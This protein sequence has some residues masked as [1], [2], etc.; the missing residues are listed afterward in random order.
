MLLFGGDTGKPTAAISNGNPPV[1]EL[2]FPPGQR[3][4]GGVI[5]YRDVADIDDL[6][7]AAAELRH[8]LREAQER[9]NGHQA[10]DL[11]VG[12][13]MEVLIDP[14][15][16]AGKHQSCVG[17]PCTCSCHSEPGMFRLMCA[18]PGDCPLGPA[19]HQYAAPAGEG[20]CC[21]RQ[22]WEPRPVEDVPLPEPERW[23]KVAAVPDLP[24]RAPGH[25][26]DQLEGRTIYPELS[27]A[28]LAGETPLDS[29]AADPEAGDD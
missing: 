19:P 3:W 25:A 17:R 22:P 26:L 15:C 9:H 11:G 13:F 23:Q 10:I 1:G 6:L 27:E 7:R 5:T 21:C 28:A 2:Q 14:D 29:L 20:P 16:I 8:L 18:V 24:H 4:P 12:A